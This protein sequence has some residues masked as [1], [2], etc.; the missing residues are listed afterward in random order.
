ME[1]VLDSSIFF[2][3]LIKDGK[4]REIISDF[5]GSL[6]FP[7]VIFEE[8]LSHKSEILEKSGMPEL[9]LEILISKLTK[10]VEFVSTEAIIG[11]KQQA[12][13]IIKEIDKK[14]A[15]FI[16]TSLAYNNCPIWS[17]DKHFKSQGKI[18]V[19]TTE[20]IIRLLEFEGNFE[21]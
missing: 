17:D 20:E 13:E 19:Y 11:F 12:Y 7:E 16:A 2:S 6:Y 3:A 1:L 18:K 9:D 8:V 15:P 5:K 14:D 4:I 21:D 10:Y